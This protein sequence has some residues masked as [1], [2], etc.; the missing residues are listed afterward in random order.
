MILYVIFA[1][2]E[3]FAIILTFFSQ[4]LWIVPNLVKTFQKSSPLWRYYVIKLKDNPYM[5]FQLYYIY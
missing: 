2:V 4:T 1:A 5:P 3:I